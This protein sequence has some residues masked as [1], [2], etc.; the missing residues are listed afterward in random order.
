[1]NPIISFSPPDIS[2]DDIQAVVQVLRSG[3]IT[4]GPVAKEFELELS[5]YVNAG[6]ALVLNSATAGLE[7]V[8]RLLDIG[9]GDEVITTP[10]TF[11][12]TANVVLHTG[13]KVV[14][15]DV[16]P[17]GF[18]I[19]PK[20]VEKKITSRTKAVIGVDYAGFTFDAKAVLEVLESK[21][22][23]YRPRKGTLQCFF[24]RP[25]LMDDAAHSL[26]A[27]YRN[28]KVGSHVDFS[29]FS[30]H[31]VKNLTTAEGGAI[32]WND[33][34][35]IEPEEL[36]RRL[37]LLSLHGQSKDAFS[38]NQKGGWRYSIEVPGYKYNMT[39]MAAALGLSQLKRYPETLEKRKS[40]FQI[41][42][43]SLGQDERLMIPDFDAEDAESS[44][45]LYTLRL[46]KPDEPERDRLI[47]RMAEAGI[48]CNVHYIP[49][50]MHPAYRKLGYCPEQTPNAFSLYQSEISLPLYTRLSEENTKW[51]ASELLRLLD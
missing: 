35:G 3:W 11:A 27:V 34:P 10:Y 22:K 28:Q 41:Y 2:E 45:H 39:D 7:L 23:S 38:K 25:V 16:V 9:P 18:H 43:N 19:D 15:A 29:V 17:G 12:A 5:K 21:K 6:H 33:I 32:T 44:Y 36:V 31:A 49:V 30:F 48:T 1:M 51:V 8:L 20:A 42:Q 46:A 50:N 13:A 40:L 4:S 14:F 37:R 24:D 47:E 26:G